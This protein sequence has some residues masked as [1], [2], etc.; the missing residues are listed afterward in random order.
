[1][2]DITYFFT[3]KYAFLDNFY[4]H[5]IIFDGKK[6]STTEHIYQAMK[7]EGNHPSEHIRLARLPGIAKAWGQRVKL[8]S[9]WDQIKVKA[10]LDILRLKFT[11]TDTLTQKLLDTG[12][13]K[14]TEGNSWHDNIWGDCTCSRCAKIKGH[15][16]LG[17]LLM[18][19]RKEIREG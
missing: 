14:I 1:M 15:N 19:I 3:G 9:D 7:V 13:V 2:K 8:R 12:D 5:E 18:L 11:Q 10:M 6:W 16:L 4:F 17:K